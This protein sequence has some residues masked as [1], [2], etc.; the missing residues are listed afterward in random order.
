MADNK[1]IGNVIGGHSR[2]HFPSCASYAHFAPSEAT[3]NNPKVS[4]D[5]KEHSRAV[6][7][8]LQQSGEYQPQES[9]KNEGNVVGGHK[10][11][12]AI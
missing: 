12:L 7:E 10:V 3:L 5:A 6:V 2:Y 11:R 8:D 4:E 1:N 9:Y